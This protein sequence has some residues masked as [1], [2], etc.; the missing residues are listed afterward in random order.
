MGRLTH[1]E[2][3]HLGGRVAHHEPHTRHPVYGQTHEE[4]QA[5]DA[6]HG[7][8]SKLLHKLEDAAWS[9]RST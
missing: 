8:V 1:S 6:E 2:L 3:T 7:G 9:I 4:E 5:Q